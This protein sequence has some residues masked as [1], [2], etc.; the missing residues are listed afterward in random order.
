[1]GVD[2]LSDYAERVGAR[3]TRNPP[4]IGIIADLAA[5]AG[6]TFDPAAVAPL[7]TEFYEHT[8]RFRMTIT[9]DWRPWMKPVYLLY[10]RFV[11]RP[12]GQA[13]APFDLDE[14]QRGVVSWID[15]ID[16]DHSGQVDVRA[17]VRAYEETGEPIYVGVYTVLR[18][19]ERGY[20]SVGF[21]LPSANFTATLLPRNLPA[22][23]LLH[24]SHTDLP[25]PGHYLTAVE[26][27][28]ELSAVKLPSFGE[29][30]EV[31]VDAL[32]ELRTDHRFTLAGIRFMTLHYAIERHGTALTGP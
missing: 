10:R 16:L 31:W 15:T 17:W 18:D 23:G 12:L 9:P 30:I 4:D 29:E 24:E 19:D 28:G 8:S 1:V 32:G 14:V 21:P 11:A 13:N 2:Y 3:F 22:G 6:P 7:I 26:P 27:S 5:L 20:V 25:Y